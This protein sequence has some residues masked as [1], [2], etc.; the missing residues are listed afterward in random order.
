M[1][2]TACTDGLPLTQLPL[3]LIVV[4][5]FHIATHGGSASLIK[6]SS[7]LS[8]NELDETNRAALF[9]LLY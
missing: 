9:L 8:K 7:K 2:A 5:L 4:A 3:I 6:P 1:E